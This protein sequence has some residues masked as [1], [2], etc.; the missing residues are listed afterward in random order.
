MEAGEFTICGLIQGTS[1]PGKLML[2]IKFK[3]SQLESSL[4]LRE[5]SILLCSGCLEEACPHM[6]CS[7]HNPK[8]T[9]LNV[10]LN[11]NVLQIDNHR[12]F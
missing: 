9:D 8:V 6:Q 12:K 5:A 3:D 1:D 7:L 4:L 10:N 11:Q 2:L